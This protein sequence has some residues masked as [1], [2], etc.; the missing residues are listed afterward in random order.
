[1][2]REP[3]GYDLSDD[4]D[5]KQERPQQGGVAAYPAMGEADMHAAVDMASNAGGGEVVLTDR[6]LK[7]RQVLSLREPLASWSAA[8]I[9]HLDLSR[10]RL[11]DKGAAAVVKVLA[12]NSSIKRLQLEH[13]GIGD[14]G[15]AALGDL[16]RKHSSITDVNLRK[17]A[18]TDT[19]ARALVVALHENH[20][21]QQLDISKN[22]TVS[23][24]MHEAGRLAAE[25]NTMRHKG[26]LA[27]D[28]LATLYETVEVIK[29][30]LGL[31]ASMPIVQAL[32][33]ACA[34]L[35]VGQPEPAAAEADGGDAKATPSPLHEDEEKEDGADKEPA[36]APAPA[37]SKMLLTERAEAVVNELGMPVTPVKAQ[38]SRDR[39]LRSLALGYVSTQAFCSCLWFMG[40]F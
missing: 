38:A 35:G 18:F 24:S 3:G 25:T 34:L 19:G 8:S 12:G 14:P 33:Q 26:M 31:M 27:L 39:V 40:V 13:N 28:T 6:G 16:L 9:V 2:P 30:E 15:A 37:Q 5:A 11:R 17:N 20:A 10:N 7:G 22:K 1:M 32:D 36:P 4:D 29:G 23:Y 21:I